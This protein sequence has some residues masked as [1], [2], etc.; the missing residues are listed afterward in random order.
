MGL[1]RN[2][3]Y[4]EHSDHRVVAAALQAV[5]E[6]EGRGR[7]EPEPRVPDPFDDMQF[8]G[9]DSWRW[10]FAIF[11]GAPGWTVVQTAPPEILLYG[12]PPRSGRLARRLGCA[13]FQHNVYDGASSLIVEAAPD[14]ETAVSGMH[15]E[16][17]ERFHGAPPSPE[18]AA[19]HFLIV[20]PSRAALGA[21]QRGVREVS[22]QLELVP[23]SLAETEVG[24]AM[25]FRVALTQRWLA[26]V[27]AT[28]QAARPGRGGPSWRASA[29]DVVEALA[30]AT[31]PLLDAQA[32]ADAIAAVFAG[33]NDRYADNELS[34]RYLVRHEMLPVGPSIALYLDERP[35][36][37]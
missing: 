37:A 4:L 16:Q 2:T 6:E 22:G 30:L 18:R 12:S 25:A 13:A 32:Q 26:G 36:L 31:P 29:A 19:P 11:P 21:R 7:V 20:D 17:P 15:P 33:P 9:A 34:V 8:G 14:G 35:P 10:G 1:F 28:F 24:Q 3:L 5:C 27:G 23:A